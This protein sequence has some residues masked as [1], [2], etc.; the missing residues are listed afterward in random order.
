MWINL[1]TILATIGL[2]CLALFVWSLASPDM[3]AVKVAAGVALLMF[4]MNTLLLRNLAGAIW[5]GCLWS[6][7]ALVA[8]LL[9]G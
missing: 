8:Y 3:S 9:E 5:T 1:S 6:F 7:F 2:S 4:S